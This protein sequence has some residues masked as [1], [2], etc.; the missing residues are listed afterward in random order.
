MPGGPLSPLLAA[1]LLDD[2]DNELESRG[3]RV[4]RY[5]DEFFVSTKTREAARRVYAL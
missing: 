5:A 1:I 3:H 2:F 4:V